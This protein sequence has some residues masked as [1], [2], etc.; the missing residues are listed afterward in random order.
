MAWNEPGG[1]R[2]R[3]P[4]GGNKGGDG[5]P[6]LDEA[7]QKLKERFG[8]LF[9][10]SGKSSNGGNKTLFGVAALVVLLVWG[11]SGIYQ[12]D[13]KQKA[14]ILRFGEFNRI[15]GPGLQWYP[16][17]IETKDIV[18]VT[19]EE[20]LTVSGLMLTKD[21]N[22][23]ELPVTVQ[24]IVPNAK[25]FVLNVKEPLISLR[26]ATDSAIR[27]IAGSTLFSDV[28]SEGRDQLADQIK[29][30]LQRYLDIYET[31]ISIRQVNIG[32]GKPPAQVQAAFDDVNASLKDKG[33]YIEEAESYRN[34]LV[35]KARGEAER[36]I[37]EATAYRDKVIAEAEG[38]AQRFEKL[39]VEYQRAPE[40]TRQRLYL[41]TVQQVMGNSSKV[42]VDVEGGNNMMYLPLDKLVGSQPRQ[43][44]S[45]TF[46]GSN[47]LDEAQIRNMIEDALREKTFERGNQR[48]G[49]R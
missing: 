29:V 46:G 24:Y 21:A 33:R 23:V 37:Q 45:S 8:G 13:E 6:D 38:E 47:S 4:W 15:V 10:G 35:P 19:K 2:D 31:G 5:P 17:L 1:G 40:V 20:S 44:P 49:R 11:F 3:D 7:L 30:R 27:H 43:S 12:V 41:D 28:I 34:G 36:L 22:I 9:G 39:L 26:H 25:D 48:G 16:P 32:E 14:V 18:N 42:L